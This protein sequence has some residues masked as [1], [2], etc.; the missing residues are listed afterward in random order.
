MKVLI[1]ITAAKSGFGGAERNML[2][3][4][5]SLLAN[6]HRVT[7][8]SPASNKVVA[9]AFARISADVRP[10]GFLNLNG[11]VRSAQA[12]DV[13]Y[14][15]G[16]R[17]GLPWT[18]LSAIVA[19]TPAIGS[20]RSNGAGIIN[21]ICHILSSLWCN[22]IIANSSPGWRVVVG[23]AGGFC[24]VI[25]VP[26]GLAPPHIE[27][28][29]RDIDVVCLANLTDNKGQIV[30]VE[31]ISRLRSQYPNLAVDCYGKDFTSGS[32]MRSLKARGLDSFCRYHG[33]VADVW[34]VLKRAKICVL[35]SLISE[36]LPTALIEA[37]F[38][39]AA[40]IASDIGGSKDV[41]VDKVTGLL[42]QPGDIEQLARA[43]A[44]LLGQPVLRNSL[45][46]EA[47]RHA[48]RNFS[49]DAMRDGHLTAFRAALS[50]SA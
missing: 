17:R 48:R 11:F 45:A 47:L 32:L 29:V 42:V 37:S 25:H 1:V 30:L 26:N 12:H 8:Y 34:P 49:I 2:R 39:G 4:A 35:P 3:L 50:G 46:T 15:M 19:G 13:V 41:C 27:P 22:S 23:V 6:G 44:L 16:P 43:L 38:A 20:E 5:E 9:D 14:V 36:G 40:L 10:L 7:L 31:A 18:F 21:Q 28:A 33:A 24:D